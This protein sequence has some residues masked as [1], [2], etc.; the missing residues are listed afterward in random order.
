METKASPAASE[1]G[2]FCILANKV[3]I[4]HMSIKFIMENKRLPL[5]SEKEIWDV[6]NVLKIMTGIKKY[7]TTVSKCVVSK[8]LNRTRSAPAITGMDSGRMT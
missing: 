2:L 1:S 7:R 6:V 5:I 4:P 8:C 3:A